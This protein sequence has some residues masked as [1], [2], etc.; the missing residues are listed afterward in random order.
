[1]RT[2]H[3]PFDTSRWLGPS[4]ALAPLA[5]T[6][7]LAALALL[8]LLARP[9]VA[10]V[11]AVP[12]ATGTGTD[13]VAANG[14]PPVIVPVTGEVVTAGIDR[15]AVLEAG[16]AQPVAFLITA[17]SR[18]RRDGAP[19]AATDLRPGDELAL[20]VDG[21]SGLVLTAAARPVPSNAPS[22][23]AALAATLGL[24][25]GGVALFFRHRAA[26]K[27]RLIARRPLAGGRPIAASI[28]RQAPIAVRPAATRFER[29]PDRE[30]SAA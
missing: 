1:M 21:Q 12:A 16:A 27:S 4:F 23:G 25:A 2:H 8:G 6:L 9:V 10:S 26:A 7:G 17:D 13:A 3:A 5:V 30:R 20:A 14:S 29:K 11:T 18:F 24:V 15:L 22:A 28:A 19:V